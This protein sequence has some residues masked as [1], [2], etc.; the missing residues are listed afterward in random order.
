MNVL[1]CVKRVPATGG[2][3]ALTADGQ[4]IDTRYLGFTISPHEEC[5]VEEA[6]RLAETHG[7]SSTV[8]TLGPEVATE[9]LRDAMAIGIDRAILLEA[10]QGEWDPM[11]TANAIVDAIR[12][13][14]AAGRE[15]DLLL[16]GNESADSAGYQ[17]GIRVAEA[18]DLPCVTGIKA[19]DVQDGLAS[20]RRQTESGWETAQVRMP[21]VLTVKEG[22]N[23]PRYPSLPGRL[24]AKKKDIERIQPRPQD[25]G[26]EKVRLKLPVM[27][28]HTVEILGSDGDAAPQVVEVLRRL[29]L[30]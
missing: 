19:L 4:D 2:H 1:V 13:E 21:A 20:V 29:R 18:L 9:Q 30:V 11:A 6:V 8:L 10:G 5:A 3:I 26:L 16:F 17:V 15:Y 28:A 27:A 25:A 22:I 12:S 23:L 24:K 7:G 14:R